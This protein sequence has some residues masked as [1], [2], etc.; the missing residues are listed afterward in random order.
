MA[1]ACAL[2][3]LGLTTFGGFQLWHLVTT[4]SV[5]AECVGRLLAIERQVSQRLSAGEAMNEVIETLL[6]E[7]QLECGDREICVNPDATLWTDISRE[8]RPILLVA[9]RE[10][11]QSS[12]VNRQPSSS[13]FVYA[14]DGLKELRC[15]QDDEVPEWAKPGNREVP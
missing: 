12:F 11:Q 4:P 6:A 13:T 3:V 10:F 5:E 2:A 1:T 9:L 14:I 15:L 8:D 7:G